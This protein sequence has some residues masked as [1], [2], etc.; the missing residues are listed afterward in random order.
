V[1]IH[2]KWFG[3]LAGTLKN[4]PNFLELNRSNV[5]R[6]FGRNWCFFVFHTLIL[7]RS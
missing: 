4:R 7:K 3:F 1:E 6:I 2:L 5:A